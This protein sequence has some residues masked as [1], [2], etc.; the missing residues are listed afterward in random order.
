[1]PAPGK[2][3]S[4]F[5]LRWVSVVLLCFAVGSAS[6]QDAAAPNSS[7]TQS[8]IY[9]IPLELIHDKPYVSVLVNGHG[10]HR[11]LID[12]GTGTDALVTPALAE[13]LH[14]PVVGRAH[15]TDPS[16]LGE[17]RSEIARIDSL[18]LG[19]A[20]FSDID[21]VVHKLYG[22]VNCEGVLGFTLFEDFLLTLDFPG[23]RM[24]LATGVINADAGEDA[25][26]SVLPFRM[27][28]GVPIV[29]LKIDE[30][31]FEAQID[32]GGTGLSVPEKDSK[33][34]KFGE[35]PVEFGSAESVSTRFQIK[36]A[37]L[38]SDVRLGRYT[39]TQPFIEINSAFPLV[40]IGSTPLQHFIIT[41]DQLNE[42]VRLYASQ[43]TLHLDAS[44]TTMELLNA[45]KREA[46]DRTLVPVG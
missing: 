44:P 37:R 30:Q 34:L 1:M 46:P 42:L 3:A 4:E 10:P 32:S 21:A 12:T 45:P 20:E 6:G 2:F 38:R 27:P 24:T 26:G 16:G 11:F 5:E 35:A 43:D 40:N 18:N 7:A 23:H 22:D 25:G 39:F 14:L 19:G 33:E 28:E 13:E 41:F 8:R 17:Q 9:S 31:Q 36:G 29:A 15:L